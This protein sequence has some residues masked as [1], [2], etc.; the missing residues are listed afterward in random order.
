MNQRQILFTL[1]QLNVFQ[2]VIQE[3]SFK[4]AALKLYISQ[5]AVTLKIQT[6]EKTVNTPLLKKD[7]YTKHL[8]L[9]DAGHLLIKYSTR[10]MSLCNEAFQTLQDLNNLQSGR[11]SIGGSQT[12]GT[13]ILPKM[14]GLF[15]E[16]YPHISIDLQVNSTRSIV[17]DIAKGT[18]DLGIVGGEIPN[19][20]IPIVQIL[21]YAND[22]LVLILSNFHPLSKKQQIL[23]E[24]LYSLNYITL[25]S[26]STTKNVIDN[27]LKKNGI[28]VNRLRVIMEL[29]SIEAIKNT[30]EAGL[31]C[32]F[33]SYT[34]IQKEL[35]LNI[36]SYVTIEDLILER[37]LLLVI[38]AHRYHSKAVY[39]FVQEILGFQTSS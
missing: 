28:D 14:I 30:V 29:N 20:F 5:P 24:D 7:K 37:Y 22:E 27:A 32:A 31:G 3:G 10:I 35:K 4:K 12:T 1:E 6:L 25:H 15:R 8:V 18:I 26:N 17:S 21:P 19:E 36:L 34:A 13:Y 9:T 16:N 23:K 38:N 11:L 33:V 2:T 39:S